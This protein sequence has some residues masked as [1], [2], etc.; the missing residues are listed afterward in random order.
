M[1]RAVPSPATGYQP[2]R[3][4]DDEEEGKL[5][6]Y[7]HVPRIGAGRFG[8]VS[9]VKHKI[10]GETRCWKVIP[11]K[12]L[13]EKEKQQLVA[14]VNVMRGLMH[15]NVVRYYERV[16]VKSTQCL[17]IVMEYCDAG[18]LAAAMVEA[19]KHFDGVREEVVIDVAIQMCA[20][21]SYCHNSQT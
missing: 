21:L 4:S 14:E 18:D 7:E 15:P 16:I 2:S 20:A 6:Q 11:Y 3:A 13:K 10:T 9:L 19:K 17:Y 12:G 1:P 8:E 5:K